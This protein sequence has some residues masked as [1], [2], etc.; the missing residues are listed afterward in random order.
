MAGLAETVSATLHIRMQ[1][2]SDRRRTGHFLPPHYKQLIIYV[3]CLIWCRI[4]S[5]ICLPPSRAESSQLST[6]LVYPRSYWQKTPHRQLPVSRTN[7]V[8]ARNRLLL[9]HHN[10]RMPC[11]YG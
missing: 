8:Y 9:L 10:G 7:R 5:R 6:F 2:L 4:L 11:G 3:C 1:T